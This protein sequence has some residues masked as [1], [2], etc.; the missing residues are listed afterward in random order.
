MIEVISGHNWFIDLSNAQ[1]NYM[2][3][4]CELCVYL[5][6]IAKKHNVYFLVGIISKYEMGFY[7][8]QPVKIWNCTYV[9]FVDQLR[10]WYFVIICNVIEGFQFLKK[11]WHWSIV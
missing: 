2:S 4:I 11:M 6:F 8:R 5:F 1:K 10:I 7:T 3:S 9:Y